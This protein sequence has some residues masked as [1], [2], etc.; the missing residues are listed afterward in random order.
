MCFCC[1]RSHA[2]PLSIAACSR[3]RSTCCR[4]FTS[5]CLCPAKASAI[6]TASSVA[7]AAATLSFCVSAALSLYSFTCRPQICRLC[8]SKLGTV[9]ARA[10]AFRRGGG[11]YGQLLP[12]Q[13]GGMWQMCWAR[14]DRRARE[15]RAIVCWPGAPRPLGFGWRIA[16][17]G[18]LLQKCST[19]NQQT[20][21]IE[22]RLPAVRRECPT[23]GPGRFQHPRSTGATGQCAASDRE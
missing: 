17:A 14:P 10:A 21:L 7:F 2:P 13:P 18:C 20:H 9:A 12:R 4:R 3:S 1:G 15:Y 22:P 23:P 6:F 5:C 8:N 16:A 19:N 11:H